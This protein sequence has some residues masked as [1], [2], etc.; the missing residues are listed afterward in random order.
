[1]DE[2]ATSDWWDTPFAEVEES[3][4]LP[5]ENAAAEASTAVASREP[6]T[7]GE[8]KSASLL[9]LALASMTMKRRRK[10]D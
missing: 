3:T 4:L 8:R 9:G 7:T 5:A 1:M 2:L 10:E 6:S